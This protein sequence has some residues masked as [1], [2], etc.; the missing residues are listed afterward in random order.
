MCV[1]DAKIIGGDVNSRTEEGYLLADYQR[2]IREHYGY[3]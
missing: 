2:T 1:D 3:G